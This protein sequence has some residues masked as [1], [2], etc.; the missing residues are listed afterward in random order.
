MFSS[1]SQARV[2][3][4]CVGC[5]IVVPRNFDPAIHPL[6]QRGEACGQCRTKTQ[7]RPC[8]FKDVSASKPE[9]P[10]TRVIRSTPDVQQPG[11]AATAD[12]LGNSLEQACSAACEGFRANQNSRTFGVCVATQ[13]WVEQVAPGS[14]DKQWK[15]LLDA[16][17][18]HGQK[19]GLRC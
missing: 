2:T 11:L 17:V 10:Q 5:W 19:Q 6:P 9:R 3:I 12:Y 13:K 8:S 16:C 1:F 4:P 18:R 7:K 14:K 15:R